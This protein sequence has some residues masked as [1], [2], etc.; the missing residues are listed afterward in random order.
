MTPKITLD[1]LNKKGFIFHRYDLPNY[2]LAE[3]ELAI[4]FKN[5]IKDIIKIPAGETLYYDYDTLNFGQEIKP[6]YHIIPGSFQVVIWLPDSDFIGRDFL[7]GYNGNLKKFK[8]QIG[9][10]CFMKPNDPLF[11]HG[12]SKLE[13]LNPV[14]T[15]G[16]SSLS[17]PFNENMNYDI[18][19]D[20]YSIE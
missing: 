15:L 16:I 4:F 19:I 7:Y 14:K 1:E 10:M 20:N 12:V 3:E 9:V 5:Y 8:P 18:Y 11:L 17:K 2:T 6:H 13:S